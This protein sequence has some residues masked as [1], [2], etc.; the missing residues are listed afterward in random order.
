MFSK[1]SSLMYAA[2]LFASRCTTILSWYTEPPCGIEGKLA[3]LLYGI[4]AVKGVEFGDGFNFA[5]R[6]GS[7]ANDELVYENG[8]IKTLTNRSGGINGGVSNGM[9][10]TFSVVFRPTPSISKPQKTVDLQQ[11]QNVEI[12]VT[13]RHDS[14]IV[15]RAVPVV[16]AVAAIALLDEILSKKD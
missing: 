10:I 7:T 3:S 4:P 8:T 5:D 6:Y 9:P 16:E 14:C 2:L 15:P 12:V 11:K 13:G 1:L